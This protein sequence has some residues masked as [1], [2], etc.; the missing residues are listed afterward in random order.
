MQG[1]QEV[2]RFGPQ[3]LARQRAELAV[4]GIEHDRR[5]LHHGV[6]TFMMRKYVS[7][8]GDSSS[9]LLFGQG[10]NRAT[11]QDDPRCRCGSLRGVGV[12]PARSLMATG[13]RTRAARG[14]GPAASTD[15]AACPR[16]NETPQWR[17][18]RIASSFRSAQPQPD[19]RLPGR[20]RRDRVHFYF[21]SS[22]M[23][24]Q[25]QE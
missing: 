2:D 4:G 13:N 1:G 10:P 25:P 7:G 22:P 14:G 21:C 5:I 9:G 20:W 15:L 3:D 8:L 17:R 24:A 18:M 19:E 12:T 11:R 23:R 6:F 16:A